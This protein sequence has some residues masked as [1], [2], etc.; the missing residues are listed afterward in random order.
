MQTLGKAPP[1]RRAG[2][3]I[4]KPEPTQNDTNNST[5]P[6]PPQ[7]Q[8]PSS[9]LGH[10]ASQQQKW[11]NSTSSHPPGPPSSMNIPIGHTAGH[12]THVRHIFIKTYANAREDTIKKI[13]YFHRT[14]DGL[15]DRTLEEITSLRD[16]HK[17]F[18]VSTLENIPKHPQQIQTSS[19]SR[20]QFL[21][22]RL[23]PSLKTI[24]TDLDRY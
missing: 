17:N 3:S 6:P 13:T 1:A 4:V 10:S 8:A 23:P 14:K 16:L 18:P 15:V 5:V 11:T 7:Q 2:S 9:N 22:I 12:H 21:V 24:S 20:H 19:S